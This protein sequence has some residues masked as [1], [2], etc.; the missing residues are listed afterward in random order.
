MIPKNIV[1]RFSRNLLLT[2]FMIIP[3]GVTFYFYVRAEKQIDL[4]HNQRLISFQLADELR[5][6]SDDLTRMARTYIITADQRYKQQYQDVLDIRNGTKP[7]PE[8]Y[9]ARIYWDLVLSDDKRPR[10]ASRESVPLLELMRRNGFTEQ[11]LAK[12]SEAK[13]H[14]DQLAL[15]ELETMRLVETSGPGAEAKQA[16]ARVMLHDLPYHQAKAA[17]MKPI[18]DFYVMV[19]KRTQGAVEA[20]TGLAMVLRITFIGFAIWLVLMLRWTFK[21]LRGTLGGS[22]EEVYSQ[23]A[24]L[25][26]GD[27]TSVIPLKDKQGHSIM[28]WLGETQAKLGEI[29][30]ERTKAQKEKLEMNEHLEK[31]S[32]QN[33]KVFEASPVGIVLV[34]KRKI[35]SVNRK[36]L[37]I[38]GYSPEEVLNTSTRILYPSQEAF[39]RFGQEAY[40]RITDGEIAHSEIDL[41]RKDGTVFTVNITGGAINPNDL[42]A[43]SIWIFEDITERRKVEDNLRKM[44]RAV[45]QSPAT[46]I[47]TD[48]RGTIEFVNPKFTEL[49]GYSAEE[50]VGQNPRILR[51]GQTPPEVYKK[52]WST[53]SSGK[54]WEGEFLNRSKDG[55]L[56]WEHAT[57]SPLRDANGAITHYLAIK[58]DIT[59]K[60]HIMDQLLQSQKLESIGQLAGGLAHDF[61]NI[62][63]IISGYAYLMRLESRSGRDQADNIEKI[64]AA[65]ARGA[66]LTQGL[67]AFSRKQVLNQRHQ[68]L[69]PLISNTGSFILRLIGENIELSLSM[70]DDPLLVYIDPGQI[71]QALLNL[72]TNA[73]DAMPDGGVLRF[74]SAAGVIDEKFIRTHGFGQIGSYA[75]ISVA[76]SGCGMDEQT[77]KQ[78]FE[79]FF[80]T[81]GVGKGTGLGMAMVMGIVKQHNGFIDVRS[82]VGAGTTFDIYL[83]LVDKA[84]DTPESRRS[85]DYVPERG[86]GTILVAEDEHSVRDY[87][88]KL[89]TMLGY[90]V[91]LAE[92]GQDAVEKFALLKDE[93][94]LVIFDMVMPRKSGKEAWNEIRQID[95]SIKVIYV[96]G[97]AEDIIERQGGLGPDEVLIRKPVIPRELL[98]M[99]KEMIRKVPAQ[100]TRT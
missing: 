46:I 49:T 1:N 24:R 93:I 9:S 44:S 3:I 28:G 38:M 50:A 13:Q 92:D 78:I 100:G 74:T 33:E 77:L 52:L 99:V 2:I 87:M 35:I 37:D 80:T 32:Q 29:E 4:A 55:T 30:Q 57:I 97:Y 36:F 83:P 21:S 26:K 43:G 22:I 45:E 66:E 7:R 39:E 81:K 60:K 69:N 12:L 68:N 17:I 5:Q 67:L 88:E 64:E 51:S 90:T 58:E 27:F 85:G 70:K 89:L 94:Q 54:V 8:G 95:S 75:V 16:R 98:G 11:E 47:I 6:S 61:N 56:F 79:P 15:L 82:A 84:D 63:S 96:S 62:L 73:R 91:V 72:A 20:A 31:L 40:S 14:S 48:L 59:E 34:V 76:D 86:E 25:G 53:I 18:D 19:D 42:S 41:C 23:I 71:E 10:H 65:S